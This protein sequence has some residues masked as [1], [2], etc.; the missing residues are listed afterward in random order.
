MAFVSSVMG[1]SM[2]LLPSG[3]RKGCAVW[4]VI[5]GPLALSAPMSSGESS[6]RLEVMSLTTTLLLSSLRPDGR[7]RSSSS[8]LA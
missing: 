1:L 2:F 4:K 6:T 7:C 3:R 8:N 5:V